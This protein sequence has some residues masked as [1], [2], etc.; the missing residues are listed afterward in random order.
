MF[1]MLLV[2]LV[3]VVSCKKEKEEVT[4]VPTPDYLNLKVGNYWVYE[5]WRIDTTGFTEKLQVTDC[6]YIHRDTAI[7][8]YTYFIKISNPIQTGKGPVAVP[9]EQPEIQ[10][11]RDSSGYLV[12]DSGKILF[13][14]NDFTSV[15]DTGSIGDLLWYDSKM[16]G[17][18]SLVSLGS[19][20]YTT[21]SLCQ[22]FYPMDPAYPWGVRKAYNIYAKNTGLIFYN[23][24][25]Y[26]A[27]TSYEARLIRSGNHIIGI[28]D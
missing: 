3:A 23:Y 1:S 14:Q 16:T 5:Y 18:D 12:D 28:T 24:W 21:R 11:I 25:F 17:K 4:Q 26:Y 19:V 6:A 13:A 27:G 7:N 20:N 8:G 10:I 9:A 22:T 15:L 2:L